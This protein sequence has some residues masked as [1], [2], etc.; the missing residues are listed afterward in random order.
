MDRSKLLH[1]NVSSS[2]QS[3]VGQASLWCCERPS[4]GLD[5]RLADRVHA[6]LDTATA[7]CKHG[8]K[9]QVPV[10]RLDIRV[11]LP[12]HPDDVPSRYFIIPLHAVALATFTVLTYPT[13]LSPIPPCRTT[14]WRICAKRVASRPRT[15]P[16]TM[17]FNISLATPADPTIRRLTGV[18]CSG[19]G[20][21]RS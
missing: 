5:A 4:A 19:S 15:M 13:A 8:A 14:S 16:P 11:C 17:S 18:I 6:L 10:P 7:S 12:R 20:S 1:Q 21:G 9:L 2:Q 3:E